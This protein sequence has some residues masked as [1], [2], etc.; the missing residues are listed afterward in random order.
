[1]CPSFAQLPGA[2]GGV[3]G[4]GNLVCHCLLLE[5]EDGLALV[6][7]GLG[8]RDVAHPVRR[9]GVGFVALTGPVLSQQDT[10]LAHVARL[11]F[12]R[13]DVRHLIAT[14]LDR[15]HA[16][17]FGDFPE[18]TVHVFGPEQRAALTPATYRE[19]HRYRA[20]HWAH[21]PRWQP[22]ELGQEHWLGFE[23][24]HALTGSRDEILLVPLIGH[25]RG[26]CGV[27]VKSEHG[28]LLHAGDAYFAHEEIHGNPPRCP[29]VLSVFQRAAAI[30]DGSRRRNQARLRELAYAH[31][32]VQIVCAHDASELRA[33][34]ATTASR[35]GST[36][37]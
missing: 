13:A 21:H 37:S 34:A 23:S 30:D 22:H 26:H 15:D 19:R 8:T 2:K 24:V 11:G 25:T 12:K 16:G 18:A 28:W 14:H 1:M 3:L 36:A 29:P 5:T 7:T 6:D 9:L 33:A 10:A 32:E 17:G 4:R 31:R 35:L 27:A 20:V